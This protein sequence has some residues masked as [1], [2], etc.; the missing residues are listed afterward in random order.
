MT[1]KFAWRVAIYC[2]RVFRGFRRSG[3]ERSE[4]PDNRVFVSGIIVP[5]TQNANIE[6]VQSNEIASSSRRPSGLLAMT[7]RGPDSERREKP[8]N[9][10]FVSGI[11][12]NVGRQLVCRQ[13]VRKERLNEM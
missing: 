4:K 9:R 3:S 2:D 8:D 11:I 13:Q 1:G 10:V 6:L 12:G 5:E 7:G